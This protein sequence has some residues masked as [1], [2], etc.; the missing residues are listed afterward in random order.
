M[1]PLSTEP[2]SHKRRFL[3]LELAVQPEPVGMILLYPQD[4][5][6]FMRGVSGCCLHNKLR[7]AV[8]LMHVGCDVSKCT[9]R[10]RFQEF[11][12]VS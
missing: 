9:G 3:H 8:L 10:A 12:G 4:F 7:F 11:F 1:F 5:G 6:N 2:S